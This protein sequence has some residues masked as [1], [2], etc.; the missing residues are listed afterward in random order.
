MVL[1][2]TAAAAEIDSDTT[3][4]VMTSTADDGSPGDVHVTE[5]GEIDVSGAPGT[6]IVTA[7]SDNNIT[8]EGDLIAEDTDDVV[9]IHV[10]TGRVLNIVQDGTIELIEDYDR[11]DEDDDDDD[12]GPLAIG[13]NR[14]GILVDDGN[15][16]QGD[17][18]IGD[19]GYIQ[20]EG[21]ESAG[22]IVN[23]L[24]DGTFET[25]G[26]ILATGDDAVGARLGQG[27]TGDVV[28]TGTISATGQNAS[29]LEITGDIGGAFSLDGTVTSTGFTSVSQTNYI[30]PVNVDEDTEAVE[31]R[32]DPDDLYDNAFSVYLNGSIA[33]GLLINGAVDTFTSDEDEEDETKDTVDDFDENRGTGRIYSYGSGVAL[34]IEATGSDITLGHVIETVHDTLDDDDDD[35]TDEVLA[36]F[37]YEQGL[38]NRGTILA[39]GVNI[40]FDATALRIHGADDES[41]SVTIDGGILNSGTIRATAYE[42]DALAIDLGPSVAVGELENSGTIAASVY[43]LSDNMATALQIGEGADLDKL[44]NFGT[45]SATSN[46]YGGVATA[47][48]G[49]SG[50]LTTI[51]NTGTIGASLASDGREDTGTGS[52]YAIDLRPQTAGVSLLQYER[53]PVED[54]NDDG[55]IDEDDV[56]DPYIYGDVLFGSG[57]DVFRVLGGYVSGDTDFGAG[58]SE[59]ELTDAIYAGDIIFGSEVSASISNATFAGDMQF[60]S[61][62]GTLSIA[63]DAEVAGNFT[64]TGSLLSFSI[65]D[66]DVT[67]EEDTALEL[68]SLTV[69]GTTQLT[70]QID[71]KNLRTTPFFRVSDTVSLTDDISVKPVLTSLIAEDFSVP[72]IDAATLDFS[73][74]FSTITTGMPWIYSVSLG[75]PD[76]DPGQLNLDFHLK[77][78]EEL[79][80]DPNQ[81]NAYAAVL[82]IST[83][84]DDIGAAVAELTTGKDFLQ[85]YNLLLP[86]RTDA[87]TRYLESQSNAAFSSLSEHLALSR[88]TSE[89]GNGAWIQENFT[90]V[91]VSGT[92]DSPGYNGRGLGLSLGYDWSLMGLDA[93]GIIGTMTDGRF[94]ET[95]GGLNPV[96]MKSLGIGVYA[97][98]RI[99]LFNLQAAIMYSDIDH[100]SYRKVVIGDYTSEVSG[101]WDGASMSASLLATSEL[102]SGPFQVTPRVGIDYF[103]LDQDAYQ[104]TASDGLNLAVSD[105][106]TDKLTADAGLA[107]SWTWRPRSRDRQVGPALAQFGRDTDAEPMVRAALDLGYRSTLSSTPYETEARYVGYE[108]RFTLRSS[109]KFGDAATVG[110]SFLAGSEYL[111]LRLGVGGEFSDEATVAT[112]NASI[113]L[114]F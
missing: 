55:E 53:T 28:L 12:D 80:L 105:A 70:F 44:V 56:D 9:G 47:V 6:D 3:S 18:S 83:T 14:T 69:A 4:P 39:N 106:H 68:A 19:Y 63:D 104:E 84:D 27:V 114:R 79:N 26:S 5:D 43:T 62:A 112:A 10:T 111:K 45:I 90:N 71:P 21:N 75:T 61:A 91:D 46:G 76:I 17:I 88:A 92:T 54:I 31:D 94:E 89:A 60:G 96:T 20:V 109:E 30:A 81:A 42:A 32:L 64:S 77:S 87:A 67:F 25:A 34:D 35:D 86:Q 58:R 93:V 36:V 100:S 57:N 74:E 11:E 49:T 8:I 37:S 66:S 99:S 24:L 72:L 13:N 110:L 23:P 85:A 103:S 38:I 107:L 82:E 33:S 78:A 41:A 40:G 1:S 101:E 48:L 95:T 2:G 98:D 52:A 108:E 50:T 15:A 97:S 29:G 7:D 65:A 102:G 22:V 16:F 51:E 73:G 113:K 59:F